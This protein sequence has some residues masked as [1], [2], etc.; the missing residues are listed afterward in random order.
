M[1][2][3]TR[4][5]HSSKSPNNSNIHTLA[6][7]SDSARLVSQTETL[8]LRRALPHAAA[9]SDIKQTSRETR[10]FTQASFNT[11]NL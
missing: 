3:E 11:E 8:N 6:L 1:V 4:G 7:N 5:L 10:W 9:Q 2:T